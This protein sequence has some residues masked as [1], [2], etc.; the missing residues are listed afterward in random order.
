[1]DALPSETSDI[2]TDFSFNYEPNMTN[3]VLFAPVI[4][5]ANMEVLKYRPI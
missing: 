2:Q 5:L 3:Y 4:I 1:M